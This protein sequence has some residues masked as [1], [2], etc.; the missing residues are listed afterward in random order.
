MLKFSSKRD[1]LLICLKEEFGS[2]YPSIR[3]RCPTHGTVCAQFLAS[4]DAKYEDLQRFW[5]VPLMATSDTEMKA[6]I[7]AIAS[8]ME[9]F[10]YLYELLLSSIFLRLNNKT[11]LNQTQKQNNNKTEQ[12]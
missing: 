12:N 9:A 5:E 10:Q 11:V 8:Q 3:T 1:A 4:I 2:V 6:R 7:R